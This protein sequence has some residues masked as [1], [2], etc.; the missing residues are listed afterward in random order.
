MRLSDFQTQRAFRR[1]ALFQ[2]TY[3]PLGACH[4]LVLP[5]VVPD[6][7][8]GITINRDRDFSDGEMCLAKLLA[9]H[10]ALAHV[11]AQHFTAL[12]QLQRDPVPGEDRLRELGLTPRETEVLHWIIQGKRDGEIS[13]IAGASVRTIETHVRRILGKLG[14]ETRTAAAIEAVRRCAA[15]SMPP[16]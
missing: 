6:H 9:P 2:E 8:A 10:I 13:R 7:V 16:T 3:R 14:V 12:R 11:H 5:L 15:L 4:Q 1:T